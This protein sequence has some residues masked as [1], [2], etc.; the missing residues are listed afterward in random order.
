MQHLLLAAGV[1]LIASRSQSAEGACT[2]TEPSQLAH[3]NMRHCKEGRDLENI[4]EAAS[5]IK[6]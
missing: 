2:C 6:V 4:D 3:T 5:S 1:A